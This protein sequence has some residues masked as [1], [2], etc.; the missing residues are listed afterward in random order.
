MAEKTIPQIVDHIRAVS[1]TVDD[2]KALLNSPRSRND[3][4]NPRQIHHLDFEKTICKGPCKWPPWEP[5]KCFENGCP[6]QRVGKGLH[7]RICKGVERAWSS[8]ERA[9]TGYIDQHELLTPLEA[10]F[11]GVRVR[12][13]DSSQG[14]EAEAVFSLV[15]DVNAGMGFMTALRRQNVGTSRAR[16][17]FYAVVQQQVM[18]RSPAWNKWLSGMRTLNPATS[19]IS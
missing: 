9:L 8:N 4:R 12:K 5:A 2:L 14:D 7:L 3:S 13:P 15:R 11:P 6:V 19:V 18:N 17:F 16:N 1:K 10:R